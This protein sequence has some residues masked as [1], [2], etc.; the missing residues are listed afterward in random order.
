[1]LFKKKDKGLKVII[2]GGPRTGTSFLSG[3]IGKMGFSHGNPKKIKT[4]DKHNIYGYFENLDIIRIEE[5]ILKKLDGNFHS[6]PNIKPNWSNDFK[7]EKKQ[8]K[9]IVKK[10][11]IEVYKG[12]RLLVISEL[13]E[14]TF[15]D[16]KWI[17][18]ERNV[19]DT[20]KSRFGTP[21]TI[22]EW[23]K[24]TDKRISIWNNSTAA[25]NALK[26][27]YE[28]FFHNPEKQVT[29]IASYL[30]VNLSEKQFADCMDFFKPRK[31]G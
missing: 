20:F 4:A 26:L 13:F 30:N 29:E 27:T 5:M 19:E 8:L 6:L 22:E 11:N 14:K 10:D 18:I 25:K 16:A 2:T 1:M 24:L 28:S 31:N 9:K 3:L 23:T 12:N 17:Y 7:R 15:P 21:M